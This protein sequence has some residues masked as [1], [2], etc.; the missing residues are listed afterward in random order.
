M[1]TDPIDPTVVVVGLAGT[2]YRA[3]L[4]RLAI[5]VVAAPLPD[6]FLLLEADGQLEL[7]P[8]DALDR[9]GIRAELPPERS[10]KQAR[11][12]PLVRA[13]G[14]TRL[15]IL[16]LTAGLGG[17]AYRLAD[18]GHRVRACE[19]E[20]A[21]F[22]L[23][24]SGLENARRAGRVAE[25]VGERLELVFGDA[26]DLLASRDPAADGLEA[27]YL[28]PMYPAPKRASAL[29]RRELQVLRRL[30]GP[31]ADASALLDAARGHFARVVV[32]RPT[33]APP[34]GMGVSFAIESK[35]VRFD[36]YLDPGRMGKRMETTVA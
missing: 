28:D 26:L 9:P 13:F 16:D 4:E 32:K 1:P 19:R 6:R 21:L 12:H 10:S 33:H 15:G 5:P 35:L 11:A 18:A 20:P 3:L 22:A 27:A 23:L 8:P 30:L 29:P 14:R 34:L 24:C 2:A 31:D 36:V 25:A 17:D 7:R